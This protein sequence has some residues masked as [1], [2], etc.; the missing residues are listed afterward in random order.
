M[1]AVKSPQNT[2]YKTIHKTGQSTQSV[3]QNDEQITIND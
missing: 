1:E 2:K 3:E